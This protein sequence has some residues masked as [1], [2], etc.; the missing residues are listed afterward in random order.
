MMD[1][2][3]CHCTVHAFDGISTLTSRPTVIVNANSISE[4]MNKAERDL[5]EEYR[6]AKC[7]VNSVGFAIVKKI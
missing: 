3:I 7:D 6:R 2:Y 5:K 4:A 1:R